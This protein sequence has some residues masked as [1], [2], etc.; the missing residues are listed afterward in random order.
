MDS[1][2]H[3]VLRRCGDFLHVIGSGFEIGDKNDTG[4]ICDEFAYHWTVRFADFNHNTNS[5]ISICINFADPQPRL[6]GVFEGDVSALIW[7]ELHCNRLVIDN[8]SG[9]WFNFLDDDGGYIQIVE[10]NHTVVIRHTGVNGAR[11]R[12]RKGE[13]CAH[14]AFRCPHLP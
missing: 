12:D 11:A 2:I 6:R 10:E 4:F 13:L 5:W 8:I 9:S 1:V 14:D 7:F 3:N